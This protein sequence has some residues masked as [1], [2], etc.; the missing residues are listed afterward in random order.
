MRP[1]LAGPE[2]LARVRSLAEQAGGAE[3]V[4]RALDVLREMEQL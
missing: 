1:A 2:L 4:G 3:R